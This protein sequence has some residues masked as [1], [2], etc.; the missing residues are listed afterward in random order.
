MVFDDQ[1]REKNKLA[2]YEEIIN[3]FIF[4]YKDSVFNL[5]YRMTSN[6]DDALELT[7]ET[8]MKAFVALPK[9][10]YESSPKTWLFKIALNL[11]LN[12]KRRLKLFENKKL[13]IK[14]QARDKNCNPEQSTSDKQMSKIIQSAINKLPLDQRAMILLREIEELSYEEIANILNIPMGTVKSRLSR[15]RF[16][17]KKLLLNN[18]R[19][20]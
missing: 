18:L 20:E 7:Q 3:D 12:Y 19:G 6:Y 2:A 1:P 17:L 15:A 11:S 16:F 4:K 8:F 10:R 13:E 5:L 14:I 9:F